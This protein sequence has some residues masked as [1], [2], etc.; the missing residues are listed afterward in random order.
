MKSSLHGCKDRGMCAVSS[1][2]F[3][4]LFSREAQRADPNGKVG[5]IRAT[6]YFFPNSVKSFMGDRQTDRE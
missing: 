3:G 4:W 1:L 5:T 6:H 2:E